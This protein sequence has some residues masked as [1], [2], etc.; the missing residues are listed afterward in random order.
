MLSQKEK[1]FLIP[2]GLV[3]IVV[4]AVGGYV[5]SEVGFSGGGEERQ[6]V[7]YSEESPD[8]DENKI[9][10]KVEDQMISCVMVDKSLDIVPDEGLGVYYK[11][12]LFPVETNVRHDIFVNDSAII[13]FKHF[14]GGGDPYNYDEEKWSKFA[15]QGPSYFVEMLDFSA[16]RNVSVIPT[17]SIPHEVITNDNFMGNITNVSYGDSWFIFSRGFAAFTGSVVD[18]R[19]TE[20]AYDRKFREIVIPE[21][22]TA[23]PEF[24][25]GPVHGFTVNNNTSTIG[26]MLGLLRDDTIVFSLQ[27]NTSTYIG[28]EIKNDSWIEVSVD[29]IYDVDMTVYEEVGGPRIYKPLDLIKEYGCF[30]LPTPRG[31]MVFTSHE[32]GNLNDEMD[33]WFAR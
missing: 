22:Y 18:Q 2:L 25:S 32:L 31:D 29:E 14:N 7:S 13:A 4:A 11:T 19:L 1:L 16:P 26:D 21:E 24:R 3:A 8:Q 30:A 33:V 6:I 10:T 12:R 23:D 5:I 28:Y 9:D 20:V 17:F 15:G 27:K